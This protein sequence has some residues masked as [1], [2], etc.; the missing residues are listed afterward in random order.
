VATCQFYALGKTYNLGLGFVI[1]QKMHFDG[2][3]CIGHDKILVFV[4]CTL[5]ILLAF[6]KWLSNL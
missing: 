2:S 5:D 4:I 1:G 6:Q 3:P